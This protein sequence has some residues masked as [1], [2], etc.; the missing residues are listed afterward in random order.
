MRQRGPILV[1]WMLLAGLTVGL[2]AAAYYS[3]SRPTERVAPRPPALR[4]PNAP[5]LALRAGKFTLWWEGTPEE[6]RRL[7]QDTGPSSNIHREDYAG[8]EACRNCHKPQYES[9]SHHAHRWMNA[10]IDESIVKGDFSDRRMSYLGGEVRFTKENDGYHMRLERGKFQRDYLIDMTIGSRFFQYYTGK[11]LA[12]PERADHPVYV[13]SHVLPLGYWVDRQEWIP[14]VHVYEDSD[15][16]QHDPYVPRVWSD[17]HTL[18][19]YVDHAPDLYRSNCNFC[20]TTFSL[21]DSLVRVQMVSGVYVPTALDLSLPEYVQA[22][23]PHL[24]PADRE[25]RHMAEQEFQTILRTF[26][27]LDA[28]DEAVTLGISCEACHLGA[29][30]HAA[31]KLKKPMFFPYG[32]ELT[33]REPHDLGRTRANVNWACGRCHTGSRPQYAAKMSTWN[34][35][36]YTDALRGSCYSELTCVRCH[37]PHE[38]L[39][40]GWSLSAV[41]ENAICLSCHQQYEPAAARTAHTHHAADSEGSRCMNC[42]MPRLNEGLQEVVRTHTIFSPTNRAMIEANHPNACN[43][44]HVDQPIDWTLARLREWYGAT[45]SEQA[46]AANYPERTAPATLGWLHGPNEAVR[47]VAADSLCRAKAEWALPDLL[48]MLDDPYLLNRQ[49]TR[50]GLEAMLGIKLSDYGYQFYMTPQERRDPLKK[51]K[52]ALLR[53]DETTADR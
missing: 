28:R 37:N 8:P 15:D 13:E 20:H 17:A 46:I 26:R 47:L 40:A 3:I 27:G 6:I 42:H 30:E 10:R 18:D 52:Q 29:K 2:A 53:A 34:S 50:I 36:E 43:Q 35:T 48:A 41:E 51:L 25:P 33:I 21:G 32:P 31:G 11:Q 7:A 9:W 16:K 23:R 4:P 19:Y 38:T 39:G 5:P 12:G 24:W 44:C 14:I 22:T 49:F 45:Y 1:A